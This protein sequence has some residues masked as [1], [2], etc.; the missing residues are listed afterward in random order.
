MAEMTLQ[1]IQSTQPRALANEFLFTMS[2][3]PPSIAF[4]FFTLLLFTIFLLVLILPVF[5]HSLPLF[6]LLFPFSFSSAKL[7]GTIFSP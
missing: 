4:H 1:A 6:P 5:P 7:K 2:S 3:P